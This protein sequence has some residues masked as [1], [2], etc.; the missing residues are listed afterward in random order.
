MKQ[1]FLTKEQIAEAIEACGH[2]PDIRGE[3]LDTETFMH[4]SDELF[5]AI[6]K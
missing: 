6:S 2:R 4:L 5:D 3:R 1:S